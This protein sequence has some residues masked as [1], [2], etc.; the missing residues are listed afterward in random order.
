T[1]GCIHAS[2]EQAADLK[3]VGTTSDAPE[4]ESIGQNPL[5]CNTTSCG[6]EYF[7]ITTQGP[8]HTAASQNEDD[9]VIDSNGDGKPHETVFKRSL[10]S[11]DILVSATED[12]S[13]NILD[14]E[15]INNR[16]GDTDTALFD[17]DTLVMP[18]AIA[19]LPGVSTGHSRIRFGVLTF[20]QFSPDPVDTVGLNSSFNPDG[21]LTTD[22]LK[23]GLAVFG[24]F[25]A[26]ANPLL[27]VDE[28]GTLNVRRDAAAYA[29]DHGQGALIVHFHNA[30][31]NKAQVVDI[32][33]TLT[34]TKHGVG[35][36]TVTSSPAG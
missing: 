33:H 7:A 8:W 16:F 13:G 19:A 32:G 9:V 17:S 23:P 26:S 36:G 4:L 11:P 21:T 3:Y 2:D 6:L 27:Y 28:P 24:T 31:G 14:V 18:V 12:L 22:A 15:L 34:V 29:A 5:T 35:K 1:T 20:S 25:N 10:T 30:V